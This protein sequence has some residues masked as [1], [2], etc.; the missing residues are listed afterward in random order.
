MQTEKEKMLS[1]LPYNPLDPELL[2]ERT[3]AR[4]LL[5]LFNA[6]LTGSSKYREILPQLLPHCSRDTVIQPP[7]F[8]DYGYNIRTGKNVFF[9]FDCVILDVCPVKIGENVMV[10]PGV[11]IYTATHPKDPVERRAAFESG[12]PVSIGND[13]WIGG[14]AVILPGI[15]IGNRCIIGAGAV[16]V[17]NVPDGKTVAGN[18]AKSVPEK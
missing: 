15:S 16:V 10:G 6:G 9:N 14:R 11:H 7:F 18:P 8:C 1:G 4:E 13:C 2:A 17:K 3:R 5:L 12:K